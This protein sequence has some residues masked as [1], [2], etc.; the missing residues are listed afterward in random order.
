MLK[1]KQLFVRP[2]KVFFIVENFI[3]YL[4]GLIFYKT[5]FGRYLIGYWKRHYPR[6]H[7]YF[8]RILSFRKETPLE[9]IVNYTKGKS[10]AIVGNA[11]SLINMSYGKDIDEHD[12][13]VRINR[14][15][16]LDS[17]SQG[18]KTD[19]WVTSF[20]YSTREL[21]YKYSIWLTPFFHSVNTVPIY[22]RFIKNPYVYRFDDYMKLSKK[23]NNSY[24]TS[25]MMA[26]DIFL[27]RMGCKSISLYGF[28]FFE[29]PNIY[30]GININ[31]SIHN[32]AEEKKYIERV[33]ANN[34]K[35]RI[36]S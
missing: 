8:K 29:S 2:Y 27:T 5:L 9:E 36:Y 10:I 19:I 24:P 17:K 31:K 12:I 6:K 34:T 30:E 1:L 14:A 11:H 22:R 35:V 18:I 15:K 33:V 23:L 25:G 26:I 28:D 32:F 7:R 21:N 20:S 13:V 3:L 16:I 4:I